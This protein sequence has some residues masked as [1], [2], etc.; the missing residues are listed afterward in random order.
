MICTGGLL[1]G[2]LIANGNKIADSFDIFQ[3]EKM[4]NFT[5]SNTKYGVHS[6]IQMIA[7]YGLKADSSMHLYLKTGERLENVLG[8]GSVLEGCSFPAGLGLGGALLTAWISTKN[9]LEVLDQ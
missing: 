8:A 9:A 6:L 4:P 5:Y 1:G 2:G 7:N 3:V